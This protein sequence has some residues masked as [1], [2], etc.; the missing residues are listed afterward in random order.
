M[1]IE[2]T[3]AEEI[4]SKDKLIN[5][6]CD[7]INNFNSKDI[8][9]ENFNLGFRYAIY[10]V[11]NLFEEKD[12]EIER[13]NNTINEIYKMII[14]HI[15]EARCELNNILHSENDLSYKNECAKEFDILDKN[16]RMIL[17]KFKEIKGEKE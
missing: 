15:E 16:I 13:L 11:S 6:I 3:E 14:G 2:E 10:K 8:G 4:L 12:K 5:S 1:N 17:D 7:T 9:N